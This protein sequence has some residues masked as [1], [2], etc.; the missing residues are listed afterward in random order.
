VANPWLHYQQGKA[1]AVDLQAILK[2]IIEDIEGLNENGGVRWKF[3]NMGKD[4]DVVFKF[5]VLFISGDTEGHDKLAAHFLSRSNVQRPC[6]Y[7]S[8]S[9]AGLADPHDSSWLYTKQ[10]VV[11][12]L[13]D[14]KDVQGLQAYSQQLVD[15]AFHSGLF[16]G[17]NFGLHGNTVAGFLRVWAHGLYLRCKHGLFSTK[18]LNERNQVVDSDGEE[19]A[20]V[21]VCTDSND[22]RPTKPAAPRNKKKNKE[23]GDGEFI[24]STAKQKVLRDKVF[25][26]GFV[27]DFDEMTKT[28]GALRAHQ[29]DRNLPL[30]RTKFSKGITSDAKM[31]AHG[32]S[33]VLLLLLM[34]LCVT[35]TSFHIVG[36]RKLLSRVLPRFST[37]LSRS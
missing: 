33:G 6:R 7:C 21:A 27:K 31:R 32:E 18:K 28:Y 3:T 11:E 35:K 1:K 4:Y 26:D 8:V 37:C 17:C 12:D 29:S 13:V 19:A 22:P 2:V 14:R 20:E 10:S 30:P 23:G 24:Y 5:T 16:H 36:V 9:F 15:V 34:M 25:S